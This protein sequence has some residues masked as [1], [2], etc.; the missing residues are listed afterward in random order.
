MLSWLLLQSHSMLPPRSST[1]CAF[2]VTYEAQLYCR[3]VLFYRHASTIT[4]F[5]LL[6]LDTDATQCSQYRYH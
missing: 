4:I 2:M 1:Y 6:W 3:W 5:G